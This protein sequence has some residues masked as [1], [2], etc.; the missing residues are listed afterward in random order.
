MSFSPRRVERCFAET[1]DPAAISSRNGRL[2]E[3]DSFPTGPPHTRSIR[4]DSRSQ[5]ASR[6]KDL[7]PPAR[8]TK[9]PK[10]GHCGPER[11]NA[12]SSHCRYNPITVVPPPMETNSHFASPWW[13]G[14]ETRAV[15]FGRSSL[16]SWVCSESS[17][18]QHRWGRV[19][20]PVGPGRLPSARPI[21]HT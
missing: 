3:D 19:Y 6:G 16:R 14:A 12:V 5:T 17:P 20:G 4:P 10:N 9:P 13:S 18:R 7:P 8:R 1:T 11:G 2:V 21:L 15:A